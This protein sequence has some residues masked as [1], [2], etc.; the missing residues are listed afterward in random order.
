MFVDNG[1]RASPDNQGPDNWGPDN[2]GLTVTRGIS[3]QE[4]K[5]KDLNNDC[6]FPSRVNMW[7]EHVIQATPV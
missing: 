5:L 6:V 4:S 2:L 3:S 1:T 7:Q